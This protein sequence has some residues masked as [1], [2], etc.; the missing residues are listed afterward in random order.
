MSEH[1]AHE[2]HGGDHGSV[3]TYGLI[4][5]ILS[6]V[7]LL[8]VGTYYVPALHERLTL[9]FV[10]LTIMAIGK[11]VLVVGYY[12][13]LKYDAAY[14]RRVFVIPLIMA[15]AMVGVVTILTATKF[16]FPAGR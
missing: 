1:S 5:A 13:H 4:L 8:E 3:R 16:I 7:T 6:V 9:L 14:Y 12:M 2:A 10:I 15:V 11:F